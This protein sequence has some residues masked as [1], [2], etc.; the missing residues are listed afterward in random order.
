M[1]RLNLASLNRQAR[2][3]QVGEKFVSGCTGK[4]A[5]KSGRAA[6][7]AVLELKQKKVN[8]NKKITTYRCTNCNK[9]HLTSH[10]PRAKEKSDG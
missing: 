4:D 7:E 2:A 9:W 5:Y 8:R 6:T 1:R 3:A 10:Q